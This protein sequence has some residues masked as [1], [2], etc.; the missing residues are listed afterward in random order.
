MSAE[1]FINRRLGMGRSLQPASLYLDE[2]GV[3]MLL[4]TG[5]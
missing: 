3:Q 2:T 1:I 4:F 5:I